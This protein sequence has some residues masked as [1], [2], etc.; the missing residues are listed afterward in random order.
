MK[1]ALVLALILVGCGSGEKA[2]DRAAKTCEPT[3]GARESVVSSPEG[4]ASRVRMSP[5]M[6]LKA[7]KRNLAAGRVGTPLV[8]TGVVRGTDCEPLPGAT[9][10]AWQTN[11][12]GRYGPVVDG[13][14]RCCYLQGTA[15]TDAEGRYTFLSV[16][17]KGYNGGAPHVHFQAGHPDAEA[18]TTELTFDGPTDEAEYDIVLRSSR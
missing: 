1:R 11:G 12:R 2:A 8:V 3:N 4:T 16:M 14:D 6:E 9:V 15:R 7:T 5:G 17:P 10:L 18:V 13:D